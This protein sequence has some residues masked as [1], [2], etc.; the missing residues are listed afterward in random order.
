MKLLDTSIF[1]DHLADTNK[2]ASDIMENDDLIF[3]SILSLF[4]V[5][6]RLI[7]LG[8]NNKKINDSMD[9][10]KKRAIIVTLN[11]E[12]IDLAVSSSVKEN[13]SAIDSMIYASALHVG[14]TLLTSDNDF[15]G[16]DNVEVLSK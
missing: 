16:L 1:L 6:K 14:V 3:C 10:V 7:K 8:L 5:K 12:I 15:R 4:E 13:L 9:F 2:E 11:E